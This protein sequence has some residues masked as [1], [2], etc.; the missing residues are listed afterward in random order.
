MAK[1]IVSA[2]CPHCGLQPSSPVTRLI[3]LLGPPELEGRSMGFDSRILF[4]FGS[5]AK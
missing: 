2:N 5:F 3:G 1:Q 4:I